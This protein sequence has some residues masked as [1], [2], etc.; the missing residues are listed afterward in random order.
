MRM[1]DAVYTAAI[2]LRLD[3]LADAMSGSAGGENG[4]DGMG[5][6]ELRELGLLVR[7]GNLILHEL[8]ES[9]FPLVAKE[10]VTVRDG[11][12]GYED[13]SRKAL[14]VRAVESGGKRVPF[15]AY[16]DCVTVP[17]GGECEVV[18]TFVSPDLTAWDSAPYAGG[19]PS[20]RLVAYG[21]AREYCLISGMAEEAVTWDGRFV[22][23]VAEESASG[24]DRRI[25][26]RVWR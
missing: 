1:W 25:R 20:A 16:Y 4:A 18:Y 19:K 9:A 15:T 6:N 8:S 23:C 11:R 3:E 7:C 22:A 2:F 24:R 5:E 10:R 14:D 17:I 12:I 21:I 13:L 26:A